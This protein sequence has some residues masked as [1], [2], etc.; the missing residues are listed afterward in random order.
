M[1]PVLIEF[2][3][4][5]R[6]WWLGSYS[7]FYTLAWLVAPVLAALV[8]SRRGLP[9]RRVLALYVVA[10][11]CGIAGARALDLVVAGAFYAQDPSRV[12]SP[13]F[14]G[15][16]L[17]GG[18]V[19]AT[20]IGI[21]LARLWDLPVWRLADSAVPALVLGVVLMRTG[22]FLRGCCFGVE[23]DLPWGVVF[24]VGSPAWEL[25]I[26]RGTSGILGFMGAVEPVHPT[27]LYEIAAVLACGAV[28][29]L[30]A[31]R[32]APE[33]VPFLAFAFGFTAFRWADHF[34]RARLDVVT[35][36]AWFYPAFYATVLVALTVLLV[37]RAWGSRGA[38]ADVRSVEPPPL[39]DGPAPPE[40]DEAGTTAPPTA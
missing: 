17:Y 31:R 40:G 30:A 3:L 1:R 21:T 7:T 9:G 15:F 14:Q 27:Q 38:T 10:L 39:P 18:L 26:A 2:A 4:F 13:T 12:W 25:Q 11:A 6:E 33:G 34:L 35:A 29:W 19:V 5:G 28:A 23:T 8:A 24:P 16:S 22:C 36:P 37:A 20:L 32:G